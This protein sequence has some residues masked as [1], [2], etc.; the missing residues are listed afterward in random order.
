MLLNV[1][2]QD[3]F[4]DTW[5]WLLDHIHGYSVQGTYHFI[6]TSGAAVDRH[7]VDDV[8]HKIIPSKVS[9]FMWRLLRD[10]LSA[11]DN[12]ATRRVI[13]ATDTACPTACGN[14]KTAKHL[15]LGCNIH[16]SLWSLVLLHW[17]GISSVLVGELRHHFLQFI[18]MVGLPRFTHL[19]L[20]VI[21]FA[22]VWV[23]WKERINRVFQNTVTIPSVL[24]EQVKLKIN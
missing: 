18:H 13:Q 6:T 9:L 24:V 19:H 7:L 8:W 20:R 1:V 11:K 4:H 5:R 22:F 15:F 3:T 21:W 2:L 17:L 16:S 23:I 14:L 10:R 12:L